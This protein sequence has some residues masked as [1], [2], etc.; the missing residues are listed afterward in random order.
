MAGPLTFKD[1]PFY[2]IRRPLTPVIECKGNACFSSI[3]GRLADQ[4]KAR[5]ST[6]DTARANID[7]PP[8]VA[9]H[10]SR[11]AN[12]RVMVFCAADMPA[13][14]PAEI[15][16]PH[17]VELK[18]NTNEVK[19]NLRGLKNKPGSTRPADITMFWR[20]CTLSPTR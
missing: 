8:D 17:Q 13:S 16:F 14:T 9:E 3:C 18:C 15:S 12:Y 19:A 5:E 11:D 10:L 2:Q 4:I 1:S 20:W 6:R 7:L